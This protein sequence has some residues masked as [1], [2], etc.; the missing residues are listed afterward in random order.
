MKF[1]Q[2]SILIMTMIIAFVGCQKETAPPQAT[3]DT[4][5]ANLFATKEP[6]GAID[7]P[8]AKKSAK[9]GDAIVVNGR[10]GGQKEP[11]AANRA[12]LTL[13]DLSLPTCDKSPMKA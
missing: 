8:T 13:A 7:I 10:I 1:A 9:D 3:T 2:M 11:L 4:L 5:P 12:I 6:P